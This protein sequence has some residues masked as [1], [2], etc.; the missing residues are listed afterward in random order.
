MATQNRKTGTGTG[1][2]A[3]N[4]RARFDYEL[5]EKFEAG[6]VLE[7][8]EVKAIRDGNVQL[9][10]SYV[11]LRDGEAWLLGANI[12]PLTSASTHVV[13]E[14]QRTRKLLLHARELARIFA[15]T[16][17][18]GFTCVA[19]ALYWKGNK[20]K[21]E[22]ALAKGKKSHDKRATTRDREWD[23]QKQRIMKH[24]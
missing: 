11:L 4:K 12:V 17:Q 6:V 5:D 21:C 22:I 20:V 14:P 15:A 3:V 1:T 10:D 19:T 16:Q 7:G 24:G 18:K 2:I 8:W 23:R 9:T 13:A